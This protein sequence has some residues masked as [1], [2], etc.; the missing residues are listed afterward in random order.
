M[1]VEN[2]IAYRFAASP[3]CFYYLVQRQLQRIYKY[4]K[5]RF[6][7]PI[8]EIIIKICLAC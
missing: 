7:E 6:S 3:K 4:D 1:L 5:N 8:P 2:G